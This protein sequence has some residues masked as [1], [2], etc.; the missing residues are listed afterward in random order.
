MFRY[1]YSTEACAGRAALSVRNVFD[2]EA[3]SELTDKAGGFRGAWLKRMALAALNYEEIV[4]IILF[5]HET[6][7]GMRWPAPMR[8][9][10]QVSSYRSPPGFPVDCMT[11]VP[12]LNTYFTRVNLNGLPVTSSS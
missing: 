10:D 11:P 2:G 8:L 5:K 6:C 12:S 9:A 7:R 1:T 4:D 3:F